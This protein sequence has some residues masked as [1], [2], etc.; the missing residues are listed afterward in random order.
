M[1]S[2]PDPIDCLLLCSESPY[3]E[4]LPGPPSLSKGAITGWEKVKPR[5]VY[6]LT[7]GSQ[8]SRRRKRHL[9]DQVLI[10]DVVSMPNLCTSTRLKSESRKKSHMS[11]YLDKDFCYVYTGGLSERS[12][13]NSDAKHKKPSH[14]SQRTSVSMC[15]LTLDPTSLFSRHSAHMVEPRTAYGEISKSF[16]MQ[17][18]PEMLAQQSLI[19]SRLRN[20]DLNAH[21][22]GDST[23]EK[24]KNTTSDGTSAVSL[25][26][27]KSPHLQ[28]SHKLKRQRR[29]NSKMW[30]PMP[31]NHESHQ[32][33]I[34]LSFKDRSH[35][36]RASNDVAGV[37]SRTRLY[38]LFGVGSFHAGK[39]CTK[40]AKMHAQFP[41]VVEKYC[42]KSSKS[43]PKQTWTKNGTL[44]YQ[45][46]FGQHQKTACVL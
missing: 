5:A 14:D 40:Q 44:T 6:D 15:N 26:N 43:E 41:R 7:A 10:C 18:K 29:L 24:G 46:I 20:L 25:V 34:D 11:G 13:A 1:E 23:S 27:A 38:G 4:V 45:I 28:Q 17:L 36:N 16:A 9:S 21:P 2:L 19:E 37:N 12:K 42:T 30:C 33:P 22:N 35:D 3:I 39:F 32:L 31:T 8:E